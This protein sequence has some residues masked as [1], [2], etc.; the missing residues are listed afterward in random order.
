[1]TRNDFEVL[2]DFFRKLPRQ[3][4]DGLNENICERCI[5]L[6]VKQLCKRLKLCNPRLSSEKFLK[7]CGF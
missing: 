2:A 4:A 5:E 3:L 1:M 7:A 6:A